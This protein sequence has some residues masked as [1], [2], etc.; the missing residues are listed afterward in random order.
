[1][2]GVFL[3]INMRSWFFWLRFILKTGPRPESKRRRGFSHQKPEITML[4]LS[5]SPHWEPAGAPGLSFLWSTVRDR[6]SLPSE[7]GLHIPFY[8]EIRGG[9]VSLV[10]QLVKNLPAMREAWTR[11]LGWEQGPLEKG[12]ATQSSML[13]WRIPWTIVHGIAES[14]TTKQLSLSRKT[15]KTAFPPLSRWH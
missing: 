11:S 10:A 1:M 14:D 9:K 13:S 2:F 7:L 6:Q 5:G 15:V 4:T 12:T 8:P 3:Q